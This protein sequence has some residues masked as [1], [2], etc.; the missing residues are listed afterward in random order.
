MGGS[1][2]INQQID[3]AKNNINNLHQEVDKLYN[4]INNE[5]DRLVGII[6]D[7]SYTDY[8]E[9]CNKITYHKVDELHSHFQIDILKEVRKL[10]RLDH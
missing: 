8:I 3:N 4:N 1:Q 10:L 7:R 6:T 2:S 9:L 5:G